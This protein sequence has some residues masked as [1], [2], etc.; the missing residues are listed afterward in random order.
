VHEAGMAGK[1]SIL[2]DFGTLYILT[3]VDHGLEKG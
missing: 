2:L 3:R 1:V